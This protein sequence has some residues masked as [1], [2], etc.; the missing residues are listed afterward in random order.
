MHSNDIVH[1][2][3]K[4][5]NVLVGPQG[6]IK[7]SDFGLSRII[8]NIDPTSNRAH[9]GAET[10]MAPELGDDEVVAKTLFSD[11]WAFGIVAYQLLEH[12]VSLEPYSY[13]SKGAASRSALKR[14]AA[15]AE[16]QPPY[17]DGQESNELTKHLMSLIAPCW[18][19]EPTS[20]PKMA[21]ILTNL[22]E[23]E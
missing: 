3:L 15:K 9:Y 11:I 17:Q 22:Y 1:A 4:P 14:M 18:V 8:R 6:Q 21:H 7:I 5:D 13:I 23:S 10:Y 20:R 16:G 19:R 12:D 2:D